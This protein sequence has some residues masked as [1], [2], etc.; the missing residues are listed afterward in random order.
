MA[1]HVSFA[2][3]TYRFSTTTDDGVSLYVDGA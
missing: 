2:A 1:P 3:G